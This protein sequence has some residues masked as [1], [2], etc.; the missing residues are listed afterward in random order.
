MAYMW[1]TVEN[2][3]RSEI[4]EIL[5]LRPGNVCCLQFRLR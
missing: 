5:P 4:V 1:E 2:H 3:L